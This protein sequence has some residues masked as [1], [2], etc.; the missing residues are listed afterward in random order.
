MN[1]VTIWVASV[2]DL[3]VRNSQ[4]ACNCWCESQECDGVR[5]SFRALAGSTRTGPLSMRGGSG[6][7]VSG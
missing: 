3:D 6:A 7:L 1:G 4:G 5:V 2:G